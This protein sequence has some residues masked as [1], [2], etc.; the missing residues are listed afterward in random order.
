MEITKEFIVEN[1]NQAL[2]FNGYELDKQELILLDKVVEKN[3]DDIACWRYGDYHYFVKSVLWKN[4]IYALKQFDLID[5][6]D[7]DFLSEVVINLEEASKI[8]ELTSMLEE[9]AK[10]DLPELNLSENLEKLAE[11]EL[12]EKEKKEKN[13]Q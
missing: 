7:L 10:E 13:F 2:Q 11:R 12:K 9:T 6:N 1:I 3:Y 5:R 8:E 4:F